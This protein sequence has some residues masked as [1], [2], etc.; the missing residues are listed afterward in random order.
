M[1]EEKFEENRL[2]SSDGLDL[3]DNGGLNEPCRNDS[4]ESDLGILGG[5]SLLINCNSE[6]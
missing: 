3:W 6:D 4:V 1:L 5:K 2:T